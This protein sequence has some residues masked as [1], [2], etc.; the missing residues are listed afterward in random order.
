MRRRSSCLT[1][2]IVT[3]QLPSSTRE[4]SDVHSAHTVILTLV[5]LHQPRDQARLQRARE[6]GP[7]V[8]RQPHQPDRHRRQQVRILARELA[9]DLVQDVVDQ[10]EEVDAPLRSL[11]QLFDLAGRRRPLGCA[12]CSTCTRPE[13][14]RRLDAASTIVPGRF[15]G[16]RPGPRSAG[17][18]QPRGLT[19]AA[20]RRRRPVRVRLRRRGVRARLR[21]RRAGSGCRR[22]RPRADGLRRARR[23]ARAAPAGERGRDPTISRQRPRT[24][25]PPGIGRHVGPALA[26]LPYDTRSS[27][28]VSCGSFKFAPV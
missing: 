22:L 17:G 9:R 26:A 23:A 11:H 4:R 13:L 8:R 21:R 18:M 7:Q 15:C 24:Q 28:G 19:V 2:P 3:I 16:R 20:L 6:L 5:A 25:R 10:L 27:L 12:R 14:D 1:A